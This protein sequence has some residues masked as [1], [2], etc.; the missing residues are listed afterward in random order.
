MPATSP[1]TN[2][3]HLLK[4]GGSLITDKEQ[5]HTL[6]PETLTR[7]AE[8]IAQ[9]RAE[10]PSLQFVLGH[11][12]GS[13]GHVVGKKFGTRQGV[14][15]RGEW[16]GFAEVWWEAISL[17]RLV[18]DAL[19]EAGL[20]GISLPPIA[21]VTARD[22][23]V[24]AWDL[25]P[26]KHVLQAGL[27]PVVFGDVVFDLERGGTILS[28]EDLFAHLAR[29]LPQTTG[30]TPGRVLLA[31]IE[32]GVWEDFPT[33]TRMIEQITPESYAGISFSVGG[34]RAADV[35]GGMASKVQ[36]SLNLVQ[37]IPRL[38]IWIFSGETP[39]AVYQSL[40]GQRV[41][42]IIHAGRQ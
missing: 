35:T 16:Q 3:L 42:T 12:S 29:H 15:S 34:S 5:A 22:A 32:A 28:T 41:G 10:D 39:G 14:H 30:L 13:F 38:E 9:A 4:L 36:L 7:L 6:R 2:K 33:C 37:E 20:P 27:L 17:N 18:M 8:E 25:T 31:G 40:L 23:R 1:N 26:L 21:S 11:G 24:T 19:H